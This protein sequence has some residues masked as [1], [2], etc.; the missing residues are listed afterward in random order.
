MN[1]RESYVVH[2]NIFEYI[3]TYIV[4]LKVFYSLCDFE[5][6]GYKQIHKWI[7]YIKRNTANSI[8]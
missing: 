7:K 1:Y 3:G 8:F 6:S 5:I 2:L 4:F